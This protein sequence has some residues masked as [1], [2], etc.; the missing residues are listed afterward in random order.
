MSDS[1]PSRTE[2]VVQDPQVANTDQAPGSIVMAPRADLA[3]AG[4]IERMAER[5]R[6]YESFDELIQ[7][8]IS[9]SGQLM[10]EA[11][12]KRDEAIATIAQSRQQVATERETQRTALTEL[13]DDVMTIQQATERLAHRVSDALEQIEFELEPIGPHDTGALAGRQTGRLS[14]GFSSQPDRF[15]SVAEAV[16]DE[17]RLGVLGQPPL[18]QASMSSASVPHGAES[19]GTGR[20]AVWSGF[21]SSVPQDDVVE[22]SNGRRANPENAELHVNQELTLDAQE[23]DD[24]GMDSTP[25]REPAA[26][27]GM[28]AAPSEARTDPW[29]SLS[30]A[31]DANTSH[32]TADREDLTGV[33]EPYAEARVEPYAEEIEPIDEV[34]FPSMQITSDVSDEG[35][36]LGPTADDVSLASEASVADLE[37]GAGSTLSFDTEPVSANATSPDVLAPRETSNSANDSGEKGTDTV[38]GSGIDVETLGVAAGNT[39]PSPGAPTEPGADAGGLTGGHDASDFVLVDETLTTTSLPDAVVVP[40]HVPAP[41]VPAVQST[42][43]QTTVVLD[44]VPRAAIALAIQRHILSKQDVLRAEVREYYDHRLTL[45]VTGRRATTADDLQ[46]WDGSATWEQIRASPELLELRMLR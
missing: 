30:D 3:G 25:E 37:L 34:A 41:V 24:H 42:E 40:H 19:T 38:T 5:L 18:N 8:N 10:R 13:L 17:Y 32:P 1:V 7:Q 23:L 9:R 29:D 16:D 45:F 35:V 2:A 22:S 36:D 12:E 27:A 26:G 46:D 39:M 33:V 21:D 44:G 14:A 28:E 6:F 43:Q 4:T 11:G 15:Q 31:V 20:A